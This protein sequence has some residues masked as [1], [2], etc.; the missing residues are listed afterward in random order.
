MSST[1]EELPKD[2]GGFIT[3]EGDIPT[4]VDKIFTED[5]KR[6]DDLQTSG[7]FELSRADGAKTLL[8]G[9]TG[10]HDGGVGRVDTF[11][12]LYL[13]DLTAHG[14]MSGYG[15]VSLWAETTDDDMKDR[16]FV[17]YTTTFPNHRRQGLGKQRLQ[18][19]NAASQQFLG[20]PLYASR[21][22]SDDSLRLWEELEQ[23]DLVVRDRGTF[24]F[25]T[26]NE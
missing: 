18:T 4:E 23:E 3:F 1:G 10:V 22:I 25:K 15:I 19:M 26:E 9:C 8:R 14:D 5:T 7:T 16:P 2:M 13:F 12:N 6:L 24:R 11:E 17:D 20:L 21:V